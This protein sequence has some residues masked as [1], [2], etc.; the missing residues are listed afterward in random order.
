MLSGNFRPLIIAVT[1]G[2]CI[3]TFRAK[4]QHWK[5]LEPASGRPYSAPF[6]RPDNWGVTAVGRAS[7][8]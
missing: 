7:Y 2:R 3:I 1:A 8:F 4:R 6:S 5:D